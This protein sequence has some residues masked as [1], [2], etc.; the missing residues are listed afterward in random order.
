M[1]RQRGAVG[2][3][4]ASGPVGHSPPVFAGPAQ[5]EF[6]WAKM[7]LLVL[8]G[9]AKDGAVAERLVAQGSSHITRLK[10]RSCLIDGE[11]VA[12]DENGVAAV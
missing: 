7:A 3:Q 9:D 4:P 5:D 11:A 8:A 1:Q 2:L 10:L 6:R 12:C